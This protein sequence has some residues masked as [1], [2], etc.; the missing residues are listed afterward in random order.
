MVVIDTDVLL[1]AFAYHRDHRQAANSRFLEWVHP[2]DP[3]ITIYNLMELLGHL[4]FNLS[5]QQFWRWPEWLLNAYG[6]SVAWPESQGQGDSTFL[7]ELL[8]QRPAGR[9]AGAGVPFMDGL[10]LDLAEQVPRAEALVTWNVRHFRG[11]GRLPVYTPEEW[12]EARA[13]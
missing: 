13:H 8:Y 4:S 10:I 12:V 9:M 2:R 6:L 1:L 3:V 5:A 11:K 7:E